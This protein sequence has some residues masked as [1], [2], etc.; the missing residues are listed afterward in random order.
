MNI[1]NYL[2][3]SQIDVNDQELLALKAIIKC[4]E[5]HELDD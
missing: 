5:D 4:I 3:L 2:L 1:P